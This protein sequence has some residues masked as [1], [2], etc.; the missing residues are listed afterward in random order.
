MRHSLTF[1]ALTCFSGV[2]HGYVGDLTTDFTSNA[3]NPDGVWTHGYFP[4]TAGVGFTAF[5]IA[6]SGPSG[7][8]WEAPS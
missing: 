6:T 4:T 7:F 2:A 8:G 1:I 5:T 3:S